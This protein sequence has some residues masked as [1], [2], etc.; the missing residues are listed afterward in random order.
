MVDARGFSCPMPVIMV[1]K[2]VKEDNPDTLEIMVDNL[3]AVENVTRFAQN[4]GYEV[5]VKSDGA[6]FVLVIGKN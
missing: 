3:C 4:L 5:E 1:Q 2:V 6:D